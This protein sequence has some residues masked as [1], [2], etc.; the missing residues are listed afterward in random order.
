MGSNPIARSDRKCHLSIRS[1][2]RQSAI[3][4][5]LQGDVAKS[6]KARVCKTPIRRFK[7]DRRLCLIDRH[8]R[9]HDSPI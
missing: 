2:Q 8:R 5:L 4:L 3:A 9:K 6:G 7:S 1:I